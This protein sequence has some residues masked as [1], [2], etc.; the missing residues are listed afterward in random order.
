MEGNGSEMHT[1]SSL[2]TMMVNLFFFFLLVCTYGL[3]VHVCECKYTHV[4]PCPCGGLRLTLTS[5]SITPY[6]LQAEPLNPTPNWLI[7][8]ILIAFWG[9]NYRWATTS[10]KHFLRVWEPD[11][12]SS[13]VCGK[14]F[15]CW[16]SSSAHVMVNLVSLMEFR[17]TAEMN[18]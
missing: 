7:W 16:A 18:F 14:P 9:W 12:L 15:N 13:C 4:Y 2:E 17:V 3:S 1:D 5:S 10:A 8:L 11:R 6:L